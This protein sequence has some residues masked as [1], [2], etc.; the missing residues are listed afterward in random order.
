MKVIGIS[1]TC[2]MS[3]MFKP[4]LCS[5][6]L[7]FGGCGGL[8]T[9]NVIK[10]SGFFDKPKP[11]VMYDT[12]SFVLLFF[13]DR[14][15]R[16]FNRVDF[17][18]FLAA[19]LILTESVFRIE[20][21]IFSPAWT[22]RFFSTKA[23]EAAPVLYWAIDSHVANNNLSRPQNFVFEHLLHN[24]WLAASFWFCVHP[25]RHRSSN[26]SSLSRENNGLSSSMNT[27]GNRI[28][29]L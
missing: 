27:C 11:P 28:L 7:F 18:T 4:L 3:L 2:K 17:F 25:R 5:F 23:F 20:R 13:A 14:S 8:L 16:R 19:L 22:P 1:V 12:F 21:N 26:V 6:A 10:L 9:S 15:F 29:S 24:I